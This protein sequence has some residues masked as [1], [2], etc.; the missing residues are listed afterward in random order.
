MKKVFAFV[1]A[2]GLIN[3]TSYSQEVAGAGSDSTAK[4][5]TVAQ[6]D[7]AKTTDVVAEESASEEEFVPEEK[8]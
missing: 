8:G 2:L 4:T 1:I 5:E 3:L 6:A 7:S